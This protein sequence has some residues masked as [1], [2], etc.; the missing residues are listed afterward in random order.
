MINIAGKKTKINGIMF[1]SKLEAEHY[2][3]LLTIPN[4]K[5][6][7]L[8]PQFLLFDSFE[9]FNIETNKKAKFSKMIYTADFELEV[10]GLDKP[11]ILESKGFQRSD[12]MLRKKLFIMLYNKDY[13][14]LQTNNMKECKAFFDRY[15]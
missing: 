7:R 6:K 10:P 9:Y 4:I 1:D 2:T 8:Q 5:I 11:L 13:H 12:Y 3:Y 14:F 15:K